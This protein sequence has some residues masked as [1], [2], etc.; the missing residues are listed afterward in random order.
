MVLIGSGLGSLSCAAL[1]AAAGRRVTLCES[2]YRP[3]GERNGGPGWNQWEFLII[4]GTGTPYI[5]MD[6]PL[7]FQWEFQDPK[8]E[9]LYH[10]FGYSLG[11][12]PLT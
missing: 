6:P 5:S 11:A 3:W 7:E 4:L 10:I 2:H 1:L 8:K 9:E 12:Y